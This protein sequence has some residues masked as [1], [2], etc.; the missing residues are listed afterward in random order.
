MS[1]FKSK[2]TKDD[3]LKEKM[4]EKVEYKNRSPNKK[5]LPKWFNRYNLVE[6]QE[7]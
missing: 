2:E 3:S 1:F 7:P 5:E 6:A 4:G